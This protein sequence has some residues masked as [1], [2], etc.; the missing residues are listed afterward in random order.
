[1]AIESQ[2]E[3]AD[4]YAARCGRG[5]AA[6]TH[7]EQHRLSLIIVCPLAIGEYHALARDSKVP[8]LQASMLKHGCYGLEGD[9]RWDD[10]AK[11]T[12]S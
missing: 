1:M 6:D 2:Y 12:S 10:D 5:V 7:H 8:A 3:V 11:A 4:Q 9:V